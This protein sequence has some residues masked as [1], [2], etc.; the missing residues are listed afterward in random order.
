MGHLAFPDLAGKEADKILPLLLTA[1]SGDVMAA[2][3]MAA[4][5]AALMCD[6]GRY[7]GAY[8]NHGFTATHPELYFHL[9]YSPFGKHVS[10]QIQL[11]YARTHRGP[12]FKCGRFG[13]G[14]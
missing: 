11:Q 12:H 2:L 13:T 5:I 10:I 9:R 6:G 14:L 8:V 1:I 7:R 4:G 3:V